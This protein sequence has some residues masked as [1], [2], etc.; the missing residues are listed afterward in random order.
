MS[1][2]MYINLYENENGVLSLGSI[3]L[4]ESKEKAESM[5]KEFPNGA[6]PKNYKATL[7]IEV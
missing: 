5:A 4:Y 6:L 3:Y 1:K 2:K 7:E